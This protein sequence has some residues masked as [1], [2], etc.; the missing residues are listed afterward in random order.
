MLVVVKMSG[1]ILVLLCTTLLGLTMAQA[2]G[3]RVL[4]LQKSISAL[5]ALEK[6]LAYSMAPPDEVVHRLAGMQSLS[7]AAYLASCAHLCKKGMPF[8][9]AWRKAVQENRGALDLADA[10][11]LEALAD[12]LG[13]CDLNTQL[14]QLRQTGAQLAQRLEQARDEYNARA[15][16]YR[17][18]GVLT[19]MFIVIVML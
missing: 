18:M 2:L 17:T 16:L 15:K 1:T 3:G 4:A 14:S 10:Q 6:D 7:V 8:P 19:G 5:D 11:V 13:Q 12:T 9:H